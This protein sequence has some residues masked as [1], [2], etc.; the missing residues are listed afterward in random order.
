M[1][2]KITDNLTKQEFEQLANRQPDFEGKWVYEL[3]QNYMD[4]DTKPPYPKF[5]LYSQKRFFLS[6]EDAL[7][8]MRQSEKKNLYCSLIVQRPADGRERGSGAA[9]LFGKDNELLDY[10][11][12]HDNS[13]DIRDCFFG[14]AEARQRFQPGDIVEVVS[15]GESVLAVLA[16]IAPDIEWCWQRYE[17]SV[18]SGEPYNR[19]YYNEIVSILGG[20]SNIYHHC[21]SPVC[22]MAPR[23]PV[24]E[25]LEKDMKTW[26]ERAK[27]EPI[28]ELQS[29]WQYRARINKVNIYR[30]I[31]GSFG[32]IVLMIDYTDKNERPAIQLT[33][34]YG[35]NVSLYIDSPDYADRRAFNGRLSNSQL[36]ALQAYLES[37][38]QGKSRW[39]YIL[40]DWNRKNE[41]LQIPLDTPIPDY[42]RLTENKTR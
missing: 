26:R 32:E 4:S 33:D 34:N 40:R 42:T 41:K 38:E 10:T 3:I 9:W 39:W 17:A 36:K 1:R 12:T 29:R 16:S 31:Y 6:Y 20:P 27:N 30:G 35:L 7:D 5:P 8:S 14:R 21:V 19:N 11:V 24:P 18:R 22:L 15:E 37:E 28:E 13:G 2:N 25:D 23:F